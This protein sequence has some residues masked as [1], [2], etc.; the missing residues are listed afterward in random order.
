[1]KQSALDVNV[2]IRN[3]VD[4]LPQVPGNII[5]TSLP[6]KELEVE[7]DPGRVGE[8]LK[9]LLP[10]RCPALLSESAISIRTSFL[11]IVNAQEA[12]DNN[13][14]VLLS[15]TFSPKPGGRT[16]RE[17]SRYMFKVIK[18]HH[19][20]MRVSRNQYLGEQVNIYLPCRR[21]TDRPQVWLRSDAQIQQSSRPHL[22]RNINAPA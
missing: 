19:G 4:G 1:M 12:G 10:Q 20:S 2:F 16:H 6:G 8:A 5:T 18:Q 13:G 15:I 3:L 17:A 22:Q 14:C 7:L 21:P 9:A 11:P